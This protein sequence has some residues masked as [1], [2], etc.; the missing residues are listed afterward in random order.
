VLPET[1]SIVTCKVTSINSNVCKVSILCVGAVHVKDPFR[2][3]IR[4]EEVRATEKD[5]VEMYKCFRPGDII[6]AK[7]VVDPIFSSSLYDI[8]KTYVEYVLSQ[9]SL[10]DAHSYILSTAENELGVIFAESEAGAAMVPVSWC[11]MQCPK[12]K[13]KENRKVAKVQT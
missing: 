9:I 13:A 10:G 7:V 4:R 11:H 3:I 5:K 1:G 8:N 12:T 6:R 2:G